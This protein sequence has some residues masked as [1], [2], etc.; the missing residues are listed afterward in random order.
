MSK[1]KILLIAGLLLAMTAASLLYLQVAFG[2]EI[3]DGGEAIFS[4][5]TQGVVDMEAEPL[6]HDILKI[7][8][9]SIDMAKPVLGLAF[10]LDYEDKKV[11]F[12]KYVPGDFLEK[13][14]NPFY[15]V[16]NDEKKKEIIFGETLRRGN[17]FPSG[18]GKVADLYFQISKKEPMN[19]H[20]KQGAV[21][22]MDTLRQDIDKIVWNDLSL[23]NNGHKITDDILSGQISNTKNGETNSMNLSANFEL[24]LGMGIVIVGL[25]GWIFVNRKKWR[26]QSV[27]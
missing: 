26:N 11:K 27:N 19:F 23:D 10:H 3:N 5:K 15:L 8:L 2:A 24:M 16:Q 9:M 20:F 7:S 4:G 17:K 13:G 21:S 22:T 1:K 25:L 6:D 18:D 14:G 12:L